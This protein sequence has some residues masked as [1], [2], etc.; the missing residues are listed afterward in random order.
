M[1]IGAFHTALFIYNTEISYCEGDG[2]HQTKAQSSHIGTYRE[3]ILLGQTQ[4]SPVDLTRILKDMQYE[5]EIF[6]VS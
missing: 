5:T 1:N 6:K 2:I 3:M 4:I